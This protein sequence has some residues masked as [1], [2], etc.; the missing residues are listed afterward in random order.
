M[1]MSKPLREQS[2]TGERLPWT[3]LGVHSST[4]NMG[5]RD[6]Q[7]DETLGLNSAWYADIL[8]TLTEH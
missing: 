6:L 1:V 4:I 8:M 5:D 3:L 2:A 7:V